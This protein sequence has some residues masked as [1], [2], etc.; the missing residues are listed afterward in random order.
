MVLSRCVSVCVRRAPPPHLFNRLICCVWSPS[1]CDAEKQNLPSALRIIKKPAAVCNHCGLSPSSVCTQTHTPA[2]HKHTNTHPWLKQK[3]PTGTAR[4]HRCTHTHTHQHASGF[5]GNWLREEE[6][7]ESNNLFRPISTID[8]CIP[9]YGGGDKGF[10]CH[11][12]MREN[13]RSDTGR[14]QSADCGR[15]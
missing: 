13:E 9:S 7:K 8:L 3:T 5:Q 2:V 12:R 11:Q 10:H 14:E 6:I 1:G 4:E 15:I